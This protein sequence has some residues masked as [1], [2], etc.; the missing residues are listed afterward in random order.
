MCITHSSCSPASNNTLLV[1][2]MN[3]GGRGSKVHHPIIVH[4]MLDNTVG[5]RIVISL[6]QIFSGTE[7]KNGLD[8]LSVMAKLLHFYAENGPF[9]SMWCCGL[10][11]FVIIF[12]LASQLHNYIF[13]INSV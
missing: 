2:V 8:Q 9:K 11:S 1:I 13:G 4:N 3:S 12:W 5:N 6:S 7:E 10:S